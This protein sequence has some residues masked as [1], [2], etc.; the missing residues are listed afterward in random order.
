MVEKEI[1]HYKENVRRMKGGGASIF[2]FS[3]PGP[4]SMNSS[5]SGSADRPIHYKKQPFK[6]AVTDPSRFSHSFVV[7]DCLTLGPHQLF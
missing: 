5:M 3:H 6:H 4:T 2:F 1:C 7:R